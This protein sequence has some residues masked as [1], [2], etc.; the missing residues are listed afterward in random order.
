MVDA[1]GGVPVCVSPRRRPTR[2]PTPAPGAHRAH[3]GRAAGYLAPGDTGSDVTG[4]ATAD[5]T[6]RLLTSTLRAAMSSDTL[7]DPVGLARFLNRAADALTVDEQTTLGDLR[8][9]ASSLGDLS[10]DAVQRAGLPVAQ[11]GY[12]PAGTDQA[13]VLLD[14]ARTRLLFD[15]V[16]E[17]SRVPAELTT[18]GADGRPAG[19]GPRGR[20]GAAAGGRRTGGARRGAPDRGAGIGHGGRPQRHRDDG[21]GR[22]GRRPAAGPGL[23]ASARWA[24]SRERSTRPSSATGPASSS[25]RAR[26]PRRCPARSCSPATRSAT[27]CSWSSARATRPSSR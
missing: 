4:A 14:G 2:R 16:I 8:V 9:L 1:L 27:P 17:G 18:E 3:R 7:L 23:R 13:Y 11:V 21:P 5:R 10:G 20:A 15:S 22:H 19:G 25:R 6:Q 12:V 26:W 24:T